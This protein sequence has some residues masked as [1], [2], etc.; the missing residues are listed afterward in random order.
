MISILSNWTVKSGAN[1]RSNRAHGTHV[2]AH[3]QTG[4]K[5]GC[6]RRCKNEKGHAG[7]RRARRTQARAGK[8]GPR[9]IRD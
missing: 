1:C 6:V 4:A 2:V 9:G 7:C 3:P 5:G 8:T